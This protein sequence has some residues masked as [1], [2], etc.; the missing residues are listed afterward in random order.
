MPPRGEISRSVSTLGASRSRSH[1][2]SN[3]TE[4]RSPWSPN[5]AQRFP[6]LSTRPKLSESGVRLFAVP[7]ATGA[8]LLSPSGH[9]TESTATTPHLSLRRGDLRSVSVRPAACTSAQAHCPTARYC[10]R[11]PGHPRRGPLVLRTAKVAGPP[12]SAS[13]RHSPRHWTTARRA[14]KPGQ[15]RPEA[16]SRI[17]FAALNTHQRLRATLHLDVRRGCRQG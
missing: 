6:T 3:R 7:R 12:R 5:C 4:A 9:V 16:V 11:S 10:S 14:S 8:L 15:L 2:L 13:S 1:P 17:G